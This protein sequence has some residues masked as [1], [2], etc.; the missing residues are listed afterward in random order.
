MRQYS[1]D[2]AKAKQLLA[3]AGYP[4]GGFK[5]LM[6]YASD[7][8]FGPKFA[9]LVKEAFAKVG[10]TVDLQ[11]LLFEQQWAKAKGPAKDRQD[12]FELLWWPGYPD[13]YD[14]LYSLFHTGV[15]GQPVLEPDLLVEQELRHRRSTRAFSDE[16][17][18]AGQGAGALQPGPA[19]CSSTQAPA[20]YL[21]DP[22]RVFGLNPES[23][24]RSPR[25]STSTTPRCS[26]GTSS[27]A[28]A[29]TLSRAV[30]LARH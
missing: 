8:T 27:H 23:Q 14:T 15:P 6:T 16:P 26:S 19:A 1:Y 30:R 20:A 28:E 18:D 3:E 10:V 13:G 9:P 11:P 7:D 17:T 29:V 2:L 24:A 25:R 22:D 5:L 21:F 4:N 12:L